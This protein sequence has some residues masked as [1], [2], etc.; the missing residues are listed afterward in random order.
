MGT[1]IVYVHGLWLTGI[2][3]YFLRKR[4]ARELAAVSY[5]FSYP[6]VR[7]DVTA[8]AAALNRFLNGIRADTLHVI[9]H[10][11]GGLVT[12]KALESEPVQRLPPGRIVLLGSPV[13]GSLT[14]ERV[15]AISPGR[16]VL[17]RGVGEELLGVRQRRWSGSRELG[18]IA[19]NLSIG[20]GRLTGAH[21]EPSDGTVFMR[22]TFLEG[23][24]DHLVVSVSH[25]GLPFSKEVARQSAH[26][27]RN[28]RFIR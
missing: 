21:D 1:A 25:T 9:G 10:S 11:L 19:G 16:A 3:G 5:V 22:E 24:R 8:N 20:L 13:Q 6:S 4:L 26:F 12:L 7:S 28:G 17:G 15:A 18:V 14:A 2:E 27:M 23:A